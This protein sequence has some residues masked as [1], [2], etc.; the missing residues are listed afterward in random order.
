MVPI[1]ILE[2]EN[3]LFDRFKPRLHVMTLGTRQHL[4]Q[5]GAGGKHGGA[6]TFFMKTF[7]G[8]KRFSTL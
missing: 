6:G 3:K 7:S 1:E 2:D 4:S 5:V 8:A